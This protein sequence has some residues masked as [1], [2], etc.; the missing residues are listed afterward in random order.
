M[1]HQPAQPIDWSHVEGHPVFHT[2]RCVCDREFR[3]H[4]KTALCSD[5]HWRGFSKDPCPDCGEHQVVASFGDPEAVTL[6]RRDFRLK[7]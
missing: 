4:H 7:P 1:S 3:S 2:L 6:E 5:G